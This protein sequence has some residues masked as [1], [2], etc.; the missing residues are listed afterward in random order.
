[1]TSTSRFVHRVKLISSE[2][3]NMAS[4]VD[5]QNSKV[6]RCNDKENKGLEKL[7]HTL[8]HLSVPS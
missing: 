8:L 5:L 7:T 1:M 3:G 6:E 4:I 2:A